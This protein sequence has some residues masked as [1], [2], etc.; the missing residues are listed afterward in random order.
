MD[1]QPETNLVDVQVEVLHAPQGHHMITRCK[2]KEHRLSLVAQNNKD[3]LRE[4]NTIK[5]S[6]KLPH[7][8]A[9]MQEE[10][11]ALH[12]NKT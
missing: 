7:C 6:L 4:L 1:H 12:T 3:T 2:A 5:E 9:T 8:R 11:N 10:I